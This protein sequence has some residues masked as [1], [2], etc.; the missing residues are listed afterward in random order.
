MPKS[1]FAVAV[2]VGLV[3]IAGQAVADE[4]PPPWQNTASLGY[5][6]TSGNTDT[7]SFALEYSLKHTPDPWGLEVLARMLRAE[8]DGDRTAER[9]E[10]GMRASRALNQ[11]WSVYAGAA[12]LKDE[13]AGLDLRWGLVA[14]AAFHLLQGPT[15]DLALNAG[16]AWTSEDPTVGSSFDYLGAELG[17][18]YAWNFSKTASLTE[19]LRFSPSFDDT[20]DWRLVSETVLKA[21][22]TSVL[23]VKLGYE[24]RYDNEPIAGFDSTDTAT[25]VSLVAKF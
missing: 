8:S 17:A 15:H 5:L 1:R 9:Y 13:F 19:A 20:D 4:P 3:C 11:R 12:A 25:T 18:A 2:L 24:W 23:A 22:L 7:Q 21:T 16:L 10:A 6:S 14:G